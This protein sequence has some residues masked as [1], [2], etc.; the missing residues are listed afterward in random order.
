MLAKVG[1]SR[2]C[3]R[4]LVTCARGFTSPGHIVPTT[5]D[6]RCRNARR[7]NCSYV[8]IRT[9][10][11]Y[12]NIQSHSTSINQTADVHSAIEKQNMSEYKNI[13]RDAL[14]IFYAGVQSVYPPQ[15]VRNAVTLSPDGDSLT[16][17][18]RKYELK[19]NVYIVGFGKAVSGM[20]R[21]LESLVGKH[22]VE[23][24]ISIPHGS[25][26]LFQ[27]IGKQELCVKEGSKVRVYEGAIT[28][29]PDEAAHTAA[30]EIL[31][32][33]ER[34]TDKDLLFVLISGGGSSLLPSPIPP[35]TLADQIE[36]TKLMSRS[37]ASIHQLN[38]LRQNVERLK[39][40]GLARIAHPATV[41]SLI[42][43]DVIGDKLD[44]ISSGP[45]S[46][47]LS[48]PRQCLQIL[49]TLGIKDAVPPAVLE[50]LALKASAKKFDQAVSPYQQKYFAN[51]SA[52]N[53]V[54]NIII[55]SNT[56][57]L[58]AAYEKAKKLNYVPIILSEAIQG[59]VRDAAY[60]FSCMAK[61]VIY[62]FGD[63]LPYEGR[64]SLVKAELELLKH[65]MTKVDVKQLSDCVG[66]S[67]NSQKDI[68]I[69][70]G[71][72]TTVNVTGSGKGGRNTE[73]ALAFSL[74][75]HQFLTEERMASKFMSN[76]HVEFLSAGTDGQDG[77]TDAAG[78]VVN[79]NFIP[80][81]LVKKLDPRQYLDN[82]DSYTLFKQLSD[83][84]SL[85]QSGLT[86]T[87]VMD[88]Q[89]L[90]VKFLR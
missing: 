87:N 40:G 39:G 42:L 44:I 45:T 38:V 54:H 52:Y 60:L 86:G 73:M 65:G 19:H 6:I 46:R 16:V 68:C 28:N 23:G 72:E 11:S 58:K 18:G 9:L 71:G 82:N 67:Y 32:L 35:M 21:A 37:G 15:M 27:A 66:Q 79:S 22:L 49:D 89:L 78:A 20:A 62:N 47:L 8:S 53:H 61:F 4:C 14:D 36:L 59:D 1:R 30:M 48:S 5:K 57:A 63:M 17:D 3:S 83:S 90:I 12:I 88:I 56:I 64:T 50:T 10:S 84:G 75:H 69:I 2:P 70:C 77:P 81:A 76:I 26:Q 55:G 7:P 25:N 13:R 31:K 41:V 85:I 51:E 80:T 29:L 74:L 33:A 43:S 34:L 24:V